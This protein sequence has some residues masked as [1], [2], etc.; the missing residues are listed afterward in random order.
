MKNGHYTRSD[1][2]ELNIYQEQG[3]AKVAVAT[4]KN[5]VKIWSD[6]CDV[7]IMDNPSDYLDKKVYMNFTKDKAPALYAAVAETVRQ[8]AYGH[9]G[10]RPGAGRKKSEDIAQKKPRSFRLTEYEYEKVKEFIENIRTESG[11]ENA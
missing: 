5:D 2:K 10:Y 7:Y 3:M 6:G 9:G 8:K 11:D 1:I 4:L